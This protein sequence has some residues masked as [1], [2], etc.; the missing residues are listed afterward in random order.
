MR[1]LQDTG[2]MKRVDEGLFFFLME[3]DA[4]QIKQMEEHT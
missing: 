1:V 4:I 3:K 2:G